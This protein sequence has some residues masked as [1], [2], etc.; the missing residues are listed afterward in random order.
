MKHV[1]SDHDLEECSR[2]VNRMM[3]LI[4]NLFFD[5]ENLLLSFID[6]TADIST[7]AP[8]K[9]KLKKESQ[10]DR[11]I[12]VFGQILEELGSQKQFEPLVCETLMTMITFAS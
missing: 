3:Q 11:L 8:P 6:S 1:N 10:S 5:S 12:N 4:R 7:M 9:G 2:E